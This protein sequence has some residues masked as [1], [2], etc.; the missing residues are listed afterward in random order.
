M[1]NIGVDI[2]GVLSNFTRSARELCKSLFNGKP[3]DRL[4]QTGWGFDSLGLSKEDEDVMWREIDSIPNWWTTHAALQGTHLL[5]PLC[6][7]HRVVFITNRKDG[8]GLPVDKQSAVW[9]TR[10]FHI[11]HP[12]VLLSNDKGPLVKALKLDYYIDDRPKNVLEVIQ[13]APRC[14]TALLDATYNQEFVHGWRVACFDDFAR[15]LVEGGN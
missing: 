6:D 13:S 14:Q 8:V 5:K 2:D 3:D 12:A 4:V 9:L 10:T 15:P 7:K 11:F 1:L